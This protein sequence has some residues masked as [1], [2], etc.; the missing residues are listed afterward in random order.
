MPKTKRG[1]TRT[2]TLKEGFRLNPKLQAELESLVE[3]AGQTKLEG[4]RET[5]FKDR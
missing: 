1:G 2:A 4:V 5:V 3:D